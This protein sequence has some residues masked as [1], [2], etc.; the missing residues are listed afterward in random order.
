MNF[1]NEK[2]FNSPSLHNRYLIG[3]IV[4]LVSVW[5]SVLLGF[6]FYLEIYFDGAIT[7][8]LIAVMSFPLVFLASFKTVSM[9]I[10]KT[11][12]IQSTLTFWVLIWLLASNTALLYFTGGKINPLIHILLLPL[13]FGMLLLSAWKFITLAFIAVIFYVWLNYFYTP[14]MSFKVHSLQAF[15]SWHLHGSMLVFMFL[16]M[17]ISVVIWPLKMRLET[18]NTLLEKKRNEALQQE[19]LMATASLAAASV[20]KLSTPLNSVQLL[21]DLLAKEVHSEQAKNYLNLAND[22]IDICIDSLQA[23]RDKAHVATKRQL[24]QVV[25]GNLL[26][27]I[28][29]EFALLHPASE[30]K[31]TI[32]GEDVPSVGL[33][34]DPTFKLALLNL[35]D[36]AARYS[37]DYIHLK[38]SKDE[39]NYVFT[40]IDQGGGLEKGILATLGQGYYNQA[41]GMGM[42]VFISRMIIERFS[43][44]IHFE[45]VVTNKRQGL[46]VEISIPLNSEV[47]SW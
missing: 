6:H 29:E 23:L 43:G 16:V 41:H 15:F 24:E 18:Q 19:Y 4:L 40:L 39:Q 32:Q 3:L 45:N 36:N 1:V 22:Q 33:N 14:I 47:E 25:M 13:V 9:K 37:P 7:A 35:C 2:A 38:A 12:L 26:T 8:L 44:K 17:V 30:L 28:K 42:G 11:G 20:H 31:I 21:Q 27:E 46:K 34:I 10:H 5:L